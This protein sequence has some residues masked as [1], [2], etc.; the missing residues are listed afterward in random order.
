MD[1]S[2]QRR[3]CAQVFQHH[4]LETSQASADAPPVTRPRSLPLIQA[5]AVPTQPYTSA[6]TT[7]LPMPTD[8][9]PPPTPSQ[10]AVA[11]TCA[12]LQ[13]L[14][15][16]DLKDLAVKYDIIPRGT[17]T[18]LAAK[19]AELPIHPSDVPA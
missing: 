19:L 2:E 6:T 12:K 5:Q 16:K 18:T 10:E 8:P 1:L 13:T 11:E 9:T 15:L 14:K 4:F 7:T 17:K 3:F